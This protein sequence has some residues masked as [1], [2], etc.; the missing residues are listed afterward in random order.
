M[1]RPF[2]I[3]FFILLY[4]LIFIEN[5]VSLETAETITVTTNIVEVNTTAGTQ[6]I[7]SPTIIITTTTSSNYSIGENENNMI[8]NFTTTENPSHGTFRP[9]IPGG[10]GV[11]KDCLRATREFQKTRKCW[12]CGNNRCHLNQNKTRVIGC[13]DDC[14]NCKQEECLC[15]T[16]CQKE[17]WFYGILIFVLIFICVQVI[18]ALACG[19]PECTKRHLRSGST[20]LSQYLNLEST[21]TENHL[22]MEDYENPYAVGNFAR[23]INCNGLLAHYNGKP[24]KIIEHLKET[25][26]FKVEVEGII[27]EVSEMKLMVS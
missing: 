4:S 12:D 2:F 5:V 23:I 21:A 10:G 25:N 1:I 18:L 9:T 16:G 20:E 6:L 3:I 26:T 22:E 13:Q 27:I 15:T 17:G 8:H 19:C 24:C 14:H 7:N 11:K